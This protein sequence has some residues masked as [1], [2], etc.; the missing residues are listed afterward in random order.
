MHPQDDIF[1]TLANIRQVEPPEEL[2]AKTLARISTSA[3][4][5]I[6]VLWV[7]VAAACL[8][9]LFASDAWVVSKQQGATRPAE[10]QIFQPNSPNILYDE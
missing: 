8:F 5:Q 6:S 9:L 7:R 2:L 1:S 4:S 3:P 10:S